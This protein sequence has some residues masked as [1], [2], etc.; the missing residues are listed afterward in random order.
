MKE[1]IKNQN[2]TFLFG[3]GASYEALPVVSNMKNRM[4]M[5]M[6]YLKN[7]TACKA[8]F[9]TRDAE[10]NKQELLGKFEDLLKEAFSH[11]TPDTFAKKLWLKDEIST[12]NDLKF[13]LSLY[14]LFEQS[15]QVPLVEDTYHYLFKDGFPEKWETDKDGKE[16]DSYIVYNKVKKQRDQ[17]YDVFF[18]TLLEKNSGELAFP[19][20]INVISWNYDLQFEM[21]YGGYIQ[22]EINNQVFQNLNVVPFVNTTK[23]KGSIVKLNGTAGIFFQGEDFVSMN[24]K[25]NFLLTGNNLV[26]S[27]FKEP[28]TPYLNFAWEL[29]K[30][31]KARIAVAEA[32]KIMAK[33]DILVI[34][35]YS[36]P[37][38]NKKIDREILQNL[39]AKTAYYQAPPNEIEG[40]S[41][42]FK[43]LMQDKD[44]EIIGIPDLRQF[45]I[46][47]QFVFPAI[48][49]VQKRGIKVR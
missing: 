1:M 12:L 14:F 11:S 49:S 24:L 41:N 27:Y 39:K 36:F 34:I 37:N 30:N 16:E 31:N 20:N 19:D 10:K 5:F 21:A 43:W 22:S 25:M 13:F 6:N 7:E 29:D 32:E 48:K 42:N 38:F 33:T 8:M 47:P 23:N 3:A 46:P 26:E 35:G 40:L 17:R 18:A 2:I 15:G 4:Q 45:F 28:K 9:S 44:I